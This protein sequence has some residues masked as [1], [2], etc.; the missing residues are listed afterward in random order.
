M[1]AAL[2]VAVLLLAMELFSKKWRK[3]THARIHAS[4]SSRKG[5][6]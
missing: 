6:R 4:L 5:R 1:I 3:N 2:V